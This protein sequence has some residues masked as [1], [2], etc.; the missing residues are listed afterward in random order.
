DGLATR[1]DGREVAEQALNDPDPIV[2][3]KAR[4]VLLSIDR[5]AGRPPS[6]KQPPNPGAQPPQPAP[7]PSPGTSGGQ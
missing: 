5:A 6:R 3:N 2:R 4:E 1:P 7:K